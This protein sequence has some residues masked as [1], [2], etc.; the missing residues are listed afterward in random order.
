M[1]PILPKSSVAGVGFP[2]I[3]SIV[4]SPGTTIIFATPM[5]PTNFG[6]GPP[7][8]P[9]PTSIILP[10][11][12]PTITLSTQSVPQPTPVILP[13][14][15]SKMGTSTSLH[16]RCPLLAPKNFLPKSE[17]ENQQRSRKCFKGRKSNPKLFKVKEAMVAQRLQ[18]TNSCDLPGGKLGDQEASVK[19]VLPKIAQGDT[20]TLI[21]VPAPIPTLKPL[22][23]S[24]FI[25]APKSSTV[26]DVKTNL[27]H[28]RNVGL[29][30]TG[31]IIAK[32]NHKN[33]AFEVQQ[34]SEPS[35]ETKITSKVKSVLE[36]QVRIRFTRDKKSHSQ[37]SLVS[38]NSHDKLDKMERDTKC[39]PSASSPIVVHKCTS[40]ESSQVE[41]PVPSGNSSLHLAAKLSPQ[42]GASQ[43]PPPP[44]PQHSY[45]KETCL[46]SQHAHLPHEYKICKTVKEINCPKAE[47][48]KLSEITEKLRE[49]KFRRRQSLS[50]CP[51]IPGHIPSPEKSL[52]NTTCA[53]N[54]VD[55]IQVPLSNLSKSS[56]SATLN[57]QHIYS[58][59][60]SPPKISK[61][62]SPQKL[63]IDNA[64]TEN[65]AC[66]SPVSP[67]YSTAPVHLKLHSKDSPS[68]ITS[69]LSAVN[70]YVEGSL[71]SPF[72]CV[73]NHSHSSCLSD[74][75][76]VGTLSGLPNSPSSSGFMYP[77]V[78]QSQYCARVSAT[79]PILSS[80][81]SDASAAAAGS[82]SCHQVSYSHQPKTSHVI[83]VEAPFLTQNSQSTSTSHT[84]L[85]S[86]FIS[87]PDTSFY[88]RSS[89]PNQCNK[90]PQKS[91]HKHSC[92]SS[93][94][95]SS[96]STS[97]VHSHQSSQETHTQSSHSPS[98]HPHSPQPAS[99]IQPLRLTS[100]TPSQ[101]S[102]HTGSPKPTL[103]MQSPHMHS[104]QLPS[105]MQPSQSPLYTQS[106]QPATRTQSPQPATHTQSSQETPYT[107]SSQASLCV[108]SPQRPSYSQ[109]LMPTSHMLSTQSVSYTKSAQQTCYE[110]FPHSN[111][112]EQSC[113]S[114]S[115]RQSP[116]PTSYIPTHHLASCAR[117]PQPSLYSYSP[118]SASFMQ[119]RHSNSHMQSEH[120]TACSESPQPQ[121]YSLQIQYHVND[122]DPPSPQALSFSSGHAS[123]YCQFPQADTCSQSSHASPVPLRASSTSAVGKDV[124]QSSHLL[125][126]SVP[127]VSPPHH[128]V[129]PA[130]ISYNN[131]YNSQ[132]SS[133][134]NYLQYYGSIK[135][136]SLASSYSA[137]EISSSFISLEKS[138]SPP[139]YEA[140][141][142]NTVSNLT[143]SPHGSTSHNTSGVYHQ[144]APTNYSL[145][146]HST[147]FEQD[148]SAVHPNPRKSVR[149]PPAYPF[150]P[151]LVPPP[152]YALNS[153]LTPTTHHSDHPTVLDVSKGSYG[154]SP[155]ESS[156]SFFPNNPPVFPPAA[157]PLNDPRPGVPFLNC[158]DYNTGQSHSMNYNSASGSTFSSVMYHPS[159]D[160]QISDNGVVSQ[161]LHNRS[162]KLTDQ[163]TFKHHHQETELTVPDWRNP[164]RGVGIHNSDSLKV[165]SL[166]ERASR[167]WFIPHQEQNRVYMKRKEMARDLLSHPDLHLSRDMMLK[168]KFWIEEDEPIAEEILLSSMTYNTEKEHKQSN[169]S[170]AKKKQI[171][172]MLCQVCGKMLK[173][174][175]SLKSHLNSHHR[176]QPHACPYCTK[177]F[178]N[179]SVLVAHLRIHTGE[180][181]Y[182]CRICDTSFRTQSS[183]TRHK[184]LHTNIRPYEC[185]MC[186]K[187]FKTKLVLQ[188]HLKLHLTGLFTCSE[189][190]KTF[191]R[192][193][194]LA[195]HKA[196]HHHASQ[197]FPCPHCHKAYQFI[198]L[199]NH[200][201][202]VHSNIRKHVCSVCSE[203]FVWRSGLAAHM[204]TH[205][206]SRPKCDICGMHFAS[207]KRLNTHYRRHSNPHPHR[208]EVCGRSFSHAYRLVSHSLT[209]HEHKE[210]ACPK[211]D[212]VFTSAKKIKKHLISH[213]KEEP[214]ICQLSGTIEIPKSTT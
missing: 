66:C 195:V 159:H 210:Y 10:S 103:H 87:H 74:K 201:M 101:L 178:T 131:A 26:A 47:T 170:H 6:V 198:S 83:P 36:D 112:Y 142:Q 20:K 115:D 73:K 126:Y 93:H 175:S 46:N 135:G 134:A 15:S 141:L 128:H 7:G 34:E 23:V 31:N 136:M 60:T 81:F 183:L 130:S 127:N 17:L 185:S 91:L 114:A 111:S 124:S 137:E 102:P 99:C 153:Q 55:E 203:S 70:S 4:A 62:D 1:K 14:S 32:E 58:S 172:E 174:R 139:S 80:E 63:L 45:M 85:P 54:N 100:C 51:S 154:Y 86:Q 13:L 200:H 129:S 105:C 48:L 106:S 38:E 202:Q 213:R 75:S 168:E 11:P 21:I 120:I 78:C 146:C 108:Q 28:S 3:R 24:S 181:P 206:T 71:D 64:I 160:V 144:I 88:T 2:Q 207:E 110:H 96:S 57:V 19:S 147:K 50:E 148:I 113:E 177:C 119:S 184:S 189:C 208:C 116:R 151:T 12:S 132:L 29:D 8:A 123:S 68:R 125:P 22:M 33:L 44:Y 171:R 59:H 194:S 43:T 76:S 72:Y 188:Q 121:G 192:H 65:Y 109:S 9:Q 104:I 69:P 40:A 94:I 140:H 90:A 30:K 150:S 209:H 205:S 118:Q 204:R 107:Q 52:T 84:T 79:S 169:K 197:K 155:E 191:E 162:Y 167:L 53:T 18:Q 27:D 133:D 92:S 158:Q 166:I 214:R 39:K 97:Y 16:S 164:T 199:L 143:S 196:S 193:K 49:R 56:Q 42:Q 89:Q 211:C 61:L 25:L 156:H 186:S 117:S 98:Y 173:G 152:T 145:S 77:S 138:L 179:R 35:H 163:Q 182:V 190:G 37:L 122:I 149:S 95:N 187:A 176:I 212:V 157:P 161:G 165:H 82:Q 41:S 5:A 67:V 180:M